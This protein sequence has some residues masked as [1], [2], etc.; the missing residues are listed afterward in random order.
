MRTLT[1]TSLNVAIF[2]AFGLSPAIILTQIQEDEWAGGYP[3]SWVRKAAIK[4]VLPT[5]PEEALRQRISGRV[6]VK[7]AITQDGN[8][9][10]IKVRPR[11]DSRLNRAVADAVKQWTFKRRPDR[12]GLG[13]PILSHLT[14][15]FLA[16]ES[17]VELD[18]PGPSAPDTERLGYYNS[19]KEQREWREWEEVEIS[20]GSPQ[21]AQP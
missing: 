12:D 13:R 1:R 20:N 15:I 19:A 3:E 21:R 17:R 5:Y 16:A 8:V 10:R 18:K 6:E 14:F 11:S 9:A 7:I 4:K 2:V